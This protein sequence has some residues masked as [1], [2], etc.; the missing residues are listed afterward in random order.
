MAETKYMPATCSNILI[1]KSD[2]H[3]KVVEIEFFVISVVSITIL[4]NVAMCQDT[5]YELVLCFELN[6]QCSD[7]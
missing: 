1:Y 4:T 3:K 7:T 6:T 2:N 5:K